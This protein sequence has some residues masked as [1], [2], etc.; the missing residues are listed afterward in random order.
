MKTW[1]KNWTSLDLVMVIGSACLLTNGGGE[2]KTD[3]KSAWIPRWHQMFMF[4]NHLDC[5][6]NPSVGGRPNTK[7]QDHGTPKSHNH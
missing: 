2:C 4:Y 6:Q 1:T 7:L 3:V 5:F